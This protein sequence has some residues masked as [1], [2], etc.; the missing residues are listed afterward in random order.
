MS[1]NEA[2][3]RPRH[4]PWRA[5]AGAV[6]WSVVV[7]GAAAALFLDVHRMDAPTRVASLDTREAASHQ[8]SR[9]PNEPP[10]FH[11]LAEA[12]FEGVAADHAAS[13]AA[14]GASPLRLA[15]PPGWQATGSEELGVDLDPD[16]PGSP[17][18]VA[19]ATFPVGLGDGVSPTWI[20]RELG[21]G[22]RSLFVSFWFKLSD[23]WQ[24]HVTGVNK[25]GFVWMHQKP[26]VA[27]AAVGTGRGPLMPELR[28]QDVQFERARNLVANVA[29]LPLVRGEWHHWEMLLVANHPDL[30]DGL[31]RWWIDG[32]LSADYNDVVL[33]GPDQEVGWQVF[34]WRPVWGGR[35]DEVRE[36]MYMWM[37]DLYISGA[38]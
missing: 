5:R 35:G 13:G 21:G 10:G 24:G 17:P 32:E 23:N 11:T 9:P 25:I 20:R 31:I 29:P 22:D 38:P 19:R 15:L 37:D 6:T 2:D 7:M 1:P 12:T 18:Y 36:T 28:L 3:H 33:A 27:F 26:V 16:A 4:T 14:S 34:A 30:R 8:V